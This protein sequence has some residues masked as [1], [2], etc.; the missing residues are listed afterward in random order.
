MK[1]KYKVYC[2]PNCISFL[3]KAKSQSS[4]FYQFIHIISLQSKV[5]PLKIQVLH[6]PPQPVLESCF[7]QHL[8]HNKT[9]GAC[10][11]CV[12]VYDC[13]RATVCVRACKRACVCV[14][15]P[16]VR[17]C[18]CARTCKCADRRKNLKQ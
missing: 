7:T 5:G 3:A 15:V 13:A 4:R 10:L 14:C 9:G 18:V 6:N 1:Y 16:V 17:A 11:P 2:F 8:F 12:R